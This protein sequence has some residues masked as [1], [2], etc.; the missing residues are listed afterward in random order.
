MRTLVALIVLS[1]SALLAAAQGAYTDLREIPDAPGA[2]GIMPVIEAFNSGETERIEAVIR[3]HFEGGFIDIPAEQHARVWGGTLAE[4]GPVEFE[5]VRRYDPPRDNLVVI[6]RAPE[7]EAWRAFVLFPG[8][9][10]RFSGMT[11][12]PARAPSYLAP[13]EPLSPEDAAAELDTL[14]DRFAEHDRFSGTV[15]IERNGEVLLERAVG[16]ASRRFDVPNRL[17]T[18]FNLGSMNKMFTAVAVARLVES[19]KLSFDDT[20]GTHLPEYPNADVRDKVQVKHLLSHTSGMGSHFT[21]EFIE[22]SKLTYR[23]TADYLP[24]FQDEPLA[25]EPGTDWQYSNAGFYLLG[26]IIEAASGE[27]YF[28]NIR[29]AVYGPASMTDTDSFDMD[30][31]IKNLAIGYTRQTFGD[32]SSDDANRWNDETGGLRN[33]LFMHSIK[34]GPAGGGFSTAPDLARFAHALTEG[35]LVSADM[36]RTLT[37]PK[38][39]LSS[40]DYGFGFGI[41]DHGPLGTVFGHSGGFPGINAMLDIYAD[42][43]LVVAVMSNTDNGAQLVGGRFME[44]LTVGK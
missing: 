3:E 44:L 36:V 19:G 24:L 22:G 33:N 7:I 43:G 16:L 5:A 15:R 8:E 21:Q 35:R 34:G 18:K 39:D 25:F 2:S 17:D 27:S 1:V 40:P 26:L 10:G 20:V 28:D 31:P 14:I 13:S 4:W 38:P 29:H 12:A 23:E 6:V 41:E 42:Q 32:V 37:T 11:T 30:V 9:G